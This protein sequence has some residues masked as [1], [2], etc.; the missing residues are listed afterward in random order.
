MKAQQTHDNRQER[1]IRS[2]WGFQPATCNLQHDLVKRLFA[3]FLF[4]LLILAGPA[5]GWAQHPRPGVQK[6][7]LTIGLAPEQNIFKLIERYTPLAEYLSGK[8]GMKIKLKALFRYGNATHNFVS[9]ELDGAFFGSFAY[10]LVHKKIGLEA[11]ARPEKEDGS[12]TYHGLIFVRTDSGIRS[13]KDMAGKRFVFVDQGTTAGFLVPLEYFK[14]QGV[15][16]YKAYLKEVYYAGTHEDAVYDVLNKRAD[17]G[18]AKNTV[19]DRLAAADMRIS[20]DLKIL[21]KS[22][23]VPEN[24]LALRK[25]VDASIRASLLEAL[26]NMHQNPAGQIVLKNFGARRFIRTA[27]KEYDPVIRMSERAGLNLAEYDFAKD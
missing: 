7:S 16:N 8:I 22:S 26:L 4:C 23:E 2:F 14:R 19:F 13:A 10:V 20:R 17:I 11:L 5:L 6:G 24:G 18:A 9:G 25:D 21:T 3:A 12:S 15:E 27:D 1:V